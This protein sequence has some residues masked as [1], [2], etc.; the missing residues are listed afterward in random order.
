MV[1]MENYEEYMLLYADGELDATGVAELMAFVKQHPQLQKELDA[2]TATRLAPDMQLQYSDKRSLLKQPEATAPKTIA[3]GNWWKYTVA[4][5]ALLLVSLLVWKLR[6]TDKQAR[7][8]VKTKQPAP[9][10]TTPVAPPVVAPTPAPQVPQQQTTTQQPQP[11]IAKQDKQPIQKK[12]TITDTAATQMAYQHKP[13]HT[14]QPPTPPAPT[15]QVTNPP[16]IVNPTPL[17]EPGAVAQNNPPTENKKKGLLQHLPLTEDR[18]AGLNQLASAVNDK[19]TRVR[20]IGENIRNTDVSVKL[21]RRE[22]FTIH[23]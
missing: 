1:T 16:T 7:E 22:L 13:T 14:P 9:S 15:P 21:G 4:A 23:F 6:D 12:K 17:P 5:A 10:T 2:Y 3:L 20:T 18:K 11:A 19:V 8:L